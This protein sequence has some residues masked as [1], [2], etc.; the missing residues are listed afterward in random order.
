M[1]LK[2]G[3]ANTS[4]AQSDVSDPKSEKRLGAPPEAV[5]NGRVAQT[6]TPTDDEAEVLQ[7]SIKAGSVAQIVV[8]AIAV[9]G[10]IYLLKLVLVTTLVA[11]LL[12]FVLE[13]MVA[14]LRR[15]HIP[16][17]AGALIA[18]LLT[19][20]L[21][22][23]LTYFFY[24]RAVDFATTLPAYSGKLRQ[25]LSKVRT[26]TGK[27]EESTRSI[28]GS[29]KDGK[30]P[31]PVEVQERPDVTRVIAAGSGAVGEV[32]LAISF[33]PFLVFFMLT[34]KDHAHLATVRLFPKEHR[35]TAHRTVGRISNMIRSFI[36]GNLLLGLINAVVSTLV[37]WR[38]GIPY[39]Y[40]VGV[41]SGFISLIPYL[42][43]FL[44]LLAPLAG[45][46]EVLDK[47]GALL[48]IL[49]VI[50]LHLLAMNFLYPMVVG[51]RLRLNPLAVTLS[52]LFW[53]WIWGAMG[54]LLAVPIV[55]A[56]KIICDY[57]EPLRGL[58]AWLGE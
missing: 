55:G 10:L 50:G 26:Q 54:L 49:T 25:V 56:T 28:M 9:L 30:Q 47:T 8:A 32:V 6:A 57:M 4:P 34:W 23:S 16:R 11:M 13:P 2:S 40:F 38:L 35:M 36:A 31:V 42:G 20:V 33:I 29:A 39:F 43:V 12:A 27:I 17:A 52:L 41:I 51:K 7:A 46:I 1:A 45:G 58:G 18:V 5:R 15:F 37:F 3:L 14:G 22:G 21:S 48:I 44:A 24:S 19:L 53:A